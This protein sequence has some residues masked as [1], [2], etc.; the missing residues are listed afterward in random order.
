[1]H[2]FFLIKIINR[3]LTH[4]VERLTLNAKWKGKHGF[5]KILKIKTHLSLKKALSVQRY[6]FSFP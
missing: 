3:G 2:F 1:M 4:N 5:C 6:A